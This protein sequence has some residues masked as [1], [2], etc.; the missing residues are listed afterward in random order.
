MKTHYNSNRS[1]AAWYDPYIKL[2]TLQH[3]D[4]EGNQ[5]G[6]ADY[7]HNRCHAFEWLHSAL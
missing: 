7:C 5:V 3:L 6:P 4:P 2:W 1:R